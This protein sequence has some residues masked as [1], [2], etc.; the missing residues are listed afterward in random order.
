[1]YLCVGFSPV[2][3]VVSPK[4]QAYVRVFP[5]GSELLEPSK[6]IV[7]PR[8]TVY[9]PPAFAVG[10][11]ETKGLLSFLL[12]GNILYAVSPMPSLFASAPV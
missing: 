2:P 11:L 7:S 5:S 10:F 9:V 6:L 12:P 1:V 8:Y 4:F 3:V